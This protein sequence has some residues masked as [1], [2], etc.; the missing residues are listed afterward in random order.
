MQN[1]RPL[2]WLAFLALAVTLSGCKWLESS[3][4]ATQ[5]TITTS[6]SYSPANCTGNC[7]GYGFPINT[8]VYGNVDE[9]L[10]GSVVNPNGYGFYNGNTSCLVCS[11]SSNL[12]VLAS[13]TYI[14]I[15][16]IVDTNWSHDVWFPDYCATPQGAYYLSSQAYQIDYQIDNV[17]MENF[18]DQ[19]WVCDTS[20][21]PPTNS[22][23]S[24]F[25]IAGT[26]PSSI[27]LPEIPGGGPFS[28]ASGPPELQIF[29]GANGI[30][31]FYYST[32]ASAKRPAED[33][34]GL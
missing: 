18:G 22:S 13:S 11:P 15:G 12:F 23:F 7:K 33:A 9:P 17:F 28:V 19:P 1:I 16:P 21:V 34:R 20:V 29:T 27:T 25:A 10:S 26:V 32:T 14:E 5:F 6:G 4:G 3:T 30:P 8:S 24:Q 31:S 2:I